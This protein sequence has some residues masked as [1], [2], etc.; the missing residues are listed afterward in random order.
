M[1]GHTARTQDGL[2]KK[3]K[4]C[5]SIWGPRRRFDYVDN[6]IELEE[7]RCECGSLSY[8]IQI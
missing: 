1:A 4:G 6:I 7:I 3:L 2:S 5:R 8:L